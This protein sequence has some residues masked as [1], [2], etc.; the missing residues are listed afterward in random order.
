MVFI[1]KNRIFHALQ[2]YR[3]VLAPRWFV[4]QFLR[5]GC[6]YHIL[7]GRDATRLLAKNKLEENVGMIFLQDVT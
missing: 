1:G 3:R 5:R 4:E 6:E 7:A 2:V